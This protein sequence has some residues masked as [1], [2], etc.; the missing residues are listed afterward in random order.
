MS[1]VV[2]TDMNR[3]FFF[4]GSLNDSFSE[5][6]DQVFEWFLPRDTVT[7]K[8][9]MPVPVL[10]AGVCY[11]RGFIYVVC[12]FTDVDKFICNKYTF[13]YNI[14]TNIWVVLYQC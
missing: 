1:G 14:R 12:G 6:S 5:L 2:A 13:R 8:K 9:S 4:G 3:V 10:D 11:D 7:L